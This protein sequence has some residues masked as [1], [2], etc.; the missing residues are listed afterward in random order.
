MWS[1]CGNQL[2]RLFVVNIGRAGQRRAGGEELEGSRQGIHIISAD[3][4]GFAATGCDA[5]R[6]HSDD[7]IDSQCLRRKSVEKKG[8]KEFT[9]V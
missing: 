1:L 7:R 9:L 4:D 3:A 8:E 2:G 6:G 5:A